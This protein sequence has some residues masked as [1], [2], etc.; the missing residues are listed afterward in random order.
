LP[1]INATCRRSVLDCCGGSAADRVNV[2][3]DM[4]AQPPHAKATNTRQAEII[5]SW[6]GAD[7]LTDAYSVEKP[8]KS[9]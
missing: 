4:P 7:D 8:A 3:R 2:A 5:P 6:L 9:K 1:L